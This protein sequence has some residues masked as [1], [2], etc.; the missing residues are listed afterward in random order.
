ML[1]VKIEQLLSDRT[2][3][4]EL[5]VLAGRSGMARRI[6]VARIQKP[7]L[8]LAGYT[9]Q[10]DRGRVQILGASEIGFLQQLPEDKQITGLDNLLALEP[11]CLVV[12]RGLNA[13]P[14]LIQRCDERNVALLTSPLVSAVFIDRVT[15]FL[16]DKLSPST[17]VHGV[18]VDVLGVGIL[19]LGKSGIGKSEAALDLVM[20]GHRLVADDIVDIRKRQPDLI[21]GSGSQ[22][23]KHHMEIRGLG[24]INI[25]DLFGVAAVRDYKKIE[26]VVE[27]VEWNEEEEYDRLGV[28]D[29]RHSILDVAV[30]MLRGP[31]PPGPH[32]T[33]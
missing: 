32:I 24:I 7:G 28:E 22:I 31:I 18:L 1:S 13:P 19:L 9:G 29:L 4:L 30:P 23:I 25:K 17:S 26:L 27:L 14:H 3:G 33:T 5:T 11:A 12:T 2:H 6:T 8:A 15:Q 10:I 20:R 16:E 21:F